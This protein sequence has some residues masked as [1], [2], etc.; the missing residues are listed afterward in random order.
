[1]ED[2][3]VTLEKDMEEHELSCLIHEVNTFTSN[4]YY[5]ECFEGHFYVLR[6]IIEW[7]ITKKFTIDVL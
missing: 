5:L 4:S 6:F 7:E 2:L 1:M 3:R